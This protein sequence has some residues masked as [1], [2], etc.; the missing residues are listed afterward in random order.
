[1]ELQKKYKVGI[2]CRLLG[3]KHAG[4]GR[5]IENLLLEIPHSSLHQQFQWVFVFHNQ[6]QWQDF[7]AECDDAAFFKAQQVLFAPIQHY[8]LYEQLSMPAIFS[9]LDLDLLH[10]PHFNIPVRYKGKLV[11]TI[12]DLLWHEYRGTQVTTLPA[13]QYWVKHEF[14]KKIVAEAVK[15]ASVVF[16]PADT[17]KSTVTRYFPT[18]EEKIRVTKEGIGKAFVETKLIHFKKN[19]A[20]VYVGSLYPHKNIDVVLEALTQLPEFSL[21][22]VGSRNIFQ[23][24]V[25]QKVHTLG[26]ENRVKFH[27]YL[28]DTELIDLFQKSFA[29]VQPSL[30]EG[31]G[32]TGVEAMS[33]GLPVIASDIP[34]F[35]EIYQDRASFFDPNS[36]DSFVMVIKE[37][38]QDPTLYQTLEHHSKVVQAEFSWQKMTEQVLQSYLHVCLA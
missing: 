13:W 36:S 1:M 2:D 29:L 12:H 17:V 15:R 18:A 9:Q 34:V 5:Y 19:D 4:I 26:L 27:G 38:Q 21:D 22:L 6:T 7:L 20:L 8:T 33:V 28:K 11:V 23:E 16:V 24:N 37:L 35:R 10:V 25:E 31:F 30:F 3:K 14:Y 32:L